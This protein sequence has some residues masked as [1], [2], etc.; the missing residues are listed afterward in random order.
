[1]SRSGP[2]RGGG[3]SAQGL[4]SRA[5]ASA[6]VLILAV[7]STALGT[8][9]VG[10]QKAPPA[11]GA[12]DCIARFGALGPE[13]Q[14]GCLRSSN[15]RVPGVN[16]EQLAQMLEA[17][18]RRT[19][20]RVIAG[21]LDLIRG[22]GY[23]ARELAGT[24]GRLLLPHQAEVHQERDK[25]YVLRLRA[26]AFVTLSEISF[27]ESAL[28]MLVDA[29]AYVDERMSSVELGAAT[30]AVGTLGESGR[31]FIPYLLSTLGERFAEEEISLERYDVAFPRQEATTVQLEV[32]RSLAAICSG[33][34]SQALTVLRAIAGNGTQSSLDPRLIREARSALKAIESRMG[35]GTPSA[36]TA[37]GTEDGARWGISVDAAGYITPWLDPAER[38]RLQRLDVGLVDHEGRDL[39]LG[40]LIDRPVLLTFFYSRCQNAGKCSTTLLKL[41]TLQ[42]DLEQKGLDRSVRLLAITYEPE[43]DV[44]LRLKRYATDRGLK[45]GDHALAARLDA[46]DHAAFVEDL[47]VPVGYNAGWVNTHGVEVVLLDAEGRLVRKYTTQAYLDNGV[48]MT[49]LQRLLEGR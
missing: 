45:L 31:P 9:F 33:Q 3:G 13:A 32:V 19:D 47:E 1:V 27:P 8:P 17:F 40:Q 49:D 41:A 21:V 5:A 38:R 24:V 36:A 12:A 4:A 2:S 26:Y 35:P 23:E 39:I 11:P 48:I 10:R 28:P 34:D 25:W 43:F 15:E 46:E 37:Q 30:R 20:H 7:A 6:F 16:N 44:P 42:D 22:R 14:L 18:D 29:L